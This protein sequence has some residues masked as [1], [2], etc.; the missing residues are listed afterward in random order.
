MDLI[1]SGLDLINEDQTVL[2]ATN[3]MLRGSYRLYPYLFQNF[4]TFGAERSVYSAILVTK[5][6]P[7]TPILRRASARIFEKGIDMNEYLFHKLYKTS[8][9]GYT[10]QSLFK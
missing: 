4:K 7:L 1:E 10:G 9:L 2:H 3:V 8:Q 6:S 5:Y